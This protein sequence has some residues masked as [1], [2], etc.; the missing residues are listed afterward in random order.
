MRNLKIVI[1]III[2]SLFEI[3]ILN[4]LHSH[5]YDLMLSGILDFFKGTCHLRPFQS[6]LLTPAII[7]LISNIT[8]LSLKTS[9]CLSWSISLIIANLI[10]FKIF[11]K[12]NK[13]IQAFGYLSAFI[14]LFILFQWSGWLYPWDTIDLITMLLFAY[15]IFSEKKLIYF[16]LVFIIG[17]FNREDSLFIPLWIIF[18]SIIY[19]QKRLIINYKKLAIGI[20]LMTTGILYI[21]YCREIL[22]K[23]ALFSNSSND[24][25]LGNHIEI[26]HNLSYLNPLSIL[27]GNETIATISILGIIF[28]SICS[29]Y[30]YKNLKVIILLIIMIVSVL[31]VGI[32]IEMRNYIMFIPFILFIASSKK[33]GGSNVIY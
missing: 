25:L 3:R 30:N 12:D 28:I 8:T 14:L 27:S 17:I 2:L 15:G 13:I 20:I 9:Y 26:F 32:I 22:F 6:R 33:T 16:I 18:D 19:S 7:L 31:F 5:N 21:G 11:Y 4:S 24:L 10:C 1:L 23:K 29:L